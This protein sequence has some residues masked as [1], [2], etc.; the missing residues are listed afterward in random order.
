MLRR[1]IKLGT[2]TR[3]QP[4]LYI[5]VKTVLVLNHDARLSTYFQL[6]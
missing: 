1:K 3:P 4:R 6:P 2:S 5:K